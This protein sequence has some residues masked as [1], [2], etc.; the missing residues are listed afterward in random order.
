MEELFSRIG[1]LCRAHPAIISLH[2]FGSMAEG[3]GRPSSDLDFAVLVE[4]G[5]SDS[6]PLLSFASALER[7]CDRQVDLIVLNRAGEV[8][9]HQVRKAG[10]LVFERDAE[11]RKRF[12]IYGRKTYED[13]LYLHRRYMKSMVT[14]NG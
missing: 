11:K 2:L 5:A 12:E 7:I 13:F 8:L 1:V 3:K 9:K 10:R 4:A 14:R 6:F